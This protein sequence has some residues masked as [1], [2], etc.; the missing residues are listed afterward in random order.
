[1]GPEFWLELCDKH[2]TTTPHDGY[3]E[4]LTIVLKRMAAVPQSTALAEE[5]P[6]RSI[7]LDALDLAR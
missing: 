2:N 5:K 1:M 6:L 4:L 3:E 7:R